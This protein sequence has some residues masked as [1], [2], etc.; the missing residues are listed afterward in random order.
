MSMP[1]PPP[2]GSHQPTPP[3]RGVPAG[4]M[5]YGGQPAKR[6][7]SGL[8]IAAGVMMLI[9]AAIVLIIGLW[10]FS[11]IESDTGRD[12][13][14]YTGNALRI[15][16]AIITGLGVALLIAG[17]GTVRS[18]TWGRIITIVLQSIFVALTL[19]GMVNSRN[20]GGAILPL[21]WG[22]TILGLAIAGKSR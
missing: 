21:A 22:G 9:Q 17:I 12:F 8:L 3:Y 2:F 19:I 20:G 1:P 15:A 7:S 10:A 4:Y 14:D 18:R 11:L 13:N 16:A 5:P 6:G